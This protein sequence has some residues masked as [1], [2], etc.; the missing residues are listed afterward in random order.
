MLKRLGRANFLFRTVRCNQHLLF[1]SNKAFPRTMQAWCM[2]DYGPGNVLKM[3][4]MEAPSSLK[5]NEV[6]VQIKAASLNPFDSLMRTGFASVALN[7]LRR[8]NRIKEFPVIP[9]RD[10]S[11]IVVKKGKMVTRVQE[12]D[13]VCHTIKNCFIIK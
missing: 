4:S 9:G 3:D 13:E 11:G 12:G 5:P 10:F 7:G 2:A 6:L 1:L 8:W